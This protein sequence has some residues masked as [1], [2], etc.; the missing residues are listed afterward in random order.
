MPKWNTEN[1]G[2]RKHLLDAAAY[3]IRECDIDGW[4]LDVA[5]EVSFD[6]W[7]DF[8]RTVRSLKP[9]FYIVGEIWHDASPWI[10]TGVF[11]TVMNYPLGQAVSDCFILKETSPETLTRRL[12]TVLTRYSDLHNRVCFNLLDSHDTDR[13]LTRA[14]GDKL[15]VKNAFTMLFLLPGSPCIYYGT[16]VG[17]EGARDPDCRRPMIWDENRQDRELRR[18][19]QNLINFRKKF[20]SLISD[21]VIDYYTRDNIHY[22]NFSRS[23]EG[24]TA[25]YTEGEPVRVEL[26]GTCV[27]GPGPVL[28]Q[29]ETELPPYTLAVFIVGSS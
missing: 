2:A 13:V 26:K 10:N 5:N 28:E 27:F 9:G 25:V 19:F 18:F 6:F 15:A 29:Y 4:R 17:M 11:D 16:E 3:W 7:N 21:C 14:K 20:F 12:F 24:L 23:G 1:P 8:S 22:W